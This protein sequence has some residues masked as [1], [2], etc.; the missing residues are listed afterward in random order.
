MGVVYV[1][2]KGECLDTMEKYY[3]YLETYRGTQ[4]DDKNTVLRN[5]IFDTLIH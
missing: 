3:I 4:I 2:W 1:I 5:R